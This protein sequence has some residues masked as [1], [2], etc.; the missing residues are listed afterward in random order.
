MYLILK[1]NH[2][3]LS[4]IFQCAKRST[5]DCK[6]ANWKWQKIFFGCRAEVLHWF[7]FQAFASQVITCYTRFFYQFQFESSYH[8]HHHYQ[9]LH[10]YQHRIVIIFKRILFN[11]PSSNNLSFLPGEKYHIKAKLT[12]MW[13]FSSFIL[14]PVSSNRQSGT[15]WTLVCPTLITI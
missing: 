6:I 1:R 7:H 13:Y 14:Q 8:H 11:H 2:L 3:K 15:F 4:H 12:L 9:H 5:N 10:H